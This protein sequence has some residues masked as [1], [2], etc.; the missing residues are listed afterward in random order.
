MI[1]KITNDFDDSEEDDCSTESQSED[2]LVVLRKEEKYLLNLFDKLELQK[3]LAT[4]LVPDAYGSYDGYRVRSVYFDSSTNED[5]F[6]KIGKSPIRKRLRMRIYSPQDQTVKFEM[7]RKKFNRQRKDSIVISRADA[8]EI[9]NGNF[10]VLLKYESSI[11]E[12]VYHLM[13]THMYRPVSIIEYDRKAY[14]HPH[15]NTRVTIDSN[16]RY[17]DSNLDFFAEKLNFKYVLPSTKS[18]L[19]VKYDRFLFRHIQYLLERC[20]FVEKPPSK[21]VSSRE[22][23]RRYYR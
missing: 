6:D 3:A 1:E 4:V 13:K 9:L 16:L 17:I 19:E 12:Y 2:N 21:Y 18:I 7:K 10:E 23:L 5:F 15:F 22:L 14:T 11:T 20:T 8:I